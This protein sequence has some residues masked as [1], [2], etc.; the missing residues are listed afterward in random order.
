MREKL[1]IIPFEQKAILTDEQ[2]RH[3]SQRAHELTQEESESLDW[4]TGD[5]ER[6][7]E[8]SARHRKMEIH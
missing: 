3:L 2:K 5:P 1:A 4:R 7:E 8:I 6:R